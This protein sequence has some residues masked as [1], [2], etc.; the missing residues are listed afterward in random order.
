M[1]LREYTVSRRL[2]KPATLL[3]DALTHQMRTSS[4]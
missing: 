4:A 1:G 3:A 2:S